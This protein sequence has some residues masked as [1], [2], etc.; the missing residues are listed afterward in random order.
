MSDNYQFWDTNLWIYLFVSSNDAIDKIKQSNLLLML[1]SEPNIAVS[2]QVLNEIANVLLKKYHFKEDAVRE[3]LE[4]IS[5]I[6][7]LI[8]MT[9]NITIEAL[10]IKKRYNVS[11]YDAL[12]VAAALHNN[13]T[14]LLSEDMQHGLVIDGKLTI[15]NPFFVKIT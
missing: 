1:E 15:Y 11:W 3:T 7:T 4:A 5:G 14:V 13:C 9:Q 2:V 8:P 10:L 12:I 6:T